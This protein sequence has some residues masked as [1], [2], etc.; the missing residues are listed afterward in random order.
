MNKLTLAAIGAASVSA[1]K[2]QSGSQATGFWDKVKNAVNNAADDISDA[3]Q[4]VGDAVV[5]VGESIGDVATS[6]YDDAV[7]I[8]ETVYEEAVDFGETAY[9]Y[10]VVAYE[11][12]LV[13]A[14][15][16]VEQEIQDGLPNV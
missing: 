16:A 8:G 4:S 7:D 13:V 2:L 15:E 6:V 9:D 5:N 11:D 3:A 1:V 10:G 12:G 14:Y